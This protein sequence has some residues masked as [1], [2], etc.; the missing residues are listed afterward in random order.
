MPE[1]N[2]LKLLQ[3]KSKNN[4]VKSSFLHLNEVNRHRSKALATFTV[5]S[6]VDKQLQL[7]LIKEIKN[8][9]IKLLRNSSIDVQYFSVIE[10]GKSL[11]NPH[12]HIQLYFE[13]EN[14]DKIQKAY[15]KTIA[16]FSLNQ[17]RC[18]LV[19]ENKNLNMKSSFNYVIKEFDNKVM[20]NNQIMALDKARSSLKQKEAKNIQLFSKS[21]ASKPHPL[22]KK[23]YYSHQL[24]YDNVNYLF[25]KGFATRLKGMRLLKAR[26]N[27]KL[28]YIVFKN[29]A[30]KLETT[31]LYHSVLFFLCFKVLIKTKILQRYIY[32]N[33][34]NVK[35]NYVIKKVRFVS[36]E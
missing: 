10:L 31:L 22:F 1:K 13:E 8:H 18:K 20:T 11:A 16:Y 30:I 5:L 36:M 33:K 23:L 29:G 19:Q 35:F 27:G 21:R 28:P 32:I 2:K 26:Q 6:L 9:F 17:K 3:L 7:I 14:I 12:T 24:T 15:Q 4:R 34:S 25:E